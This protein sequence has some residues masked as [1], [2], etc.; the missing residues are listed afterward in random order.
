MTEPTGEKY[1]VKR[2]HRELYAPSAKDFVV[3]EVPPLR[4]LAIDGHGDP[5]TSAA[6]VQAV[7][8]LFGVAY[9]VKFASKRE[10]GRDFAVAPLEGLWWAEDRAAFVARDKGAWSWTMLVNQPDWIDERAVAAGVEAVR[11]K[12]STA[13]TDANP[14]LDLLRLEHLHEGESVQILHVGSYDDEAPTL[15]RLHDEWMPQHGLAF[16]GSHHEIYLS[17]ARRTAPEKL[18]TVLRQPVRAV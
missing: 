13:A 16:N 6:Y 2:A 14:A 1:D 7:E 4:Y 8:A 10:S 5:N 3:V 9:A 18:R 11:A 15:A 12:A 17:N